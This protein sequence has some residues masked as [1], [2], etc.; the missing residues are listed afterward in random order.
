[1]NGHREWPYDRLTDLPH[2]MV[3]VSGLHQIDSLLLAIWR[4]IIEC[5]SLSALFTVHAVNFHYYRR[6]PIIAPSSTYSRIVLLWSISNWLRRRC[7][8]RF[9]YGHIDKLAHNNM[10]GNG[11]PTLYCGMEQIQTPR[12]RLIN[13]SFSWIWVRDSSDTYYW[14]TSIGQSRK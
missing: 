10:C 13:S 11:I 6:E 5:S 7:A 9:F 1:M 3:G 12:W 4:T 8:D 2:W 14:T